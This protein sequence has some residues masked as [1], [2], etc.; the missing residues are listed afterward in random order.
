VP[1]RLAAAMV[2]SGCAVIHVMVAAGAHS[3]S[4]V[5]ALVLLGMALACVPCAVHALMAPTRRSWL[6]AALVAGGMVAAHPFLRLMDAER[7][8][9]VDSGLPLL[10]SAGMT[11]G[12]VVALGLA[13]IGAFSRP[14]VG[15]AIAR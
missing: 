8:G 6:R 15:P 13:C 2:M 11:L 5:H 7:Q 3:R 10:V 14:P 1:L 12:P 4:G 9:H